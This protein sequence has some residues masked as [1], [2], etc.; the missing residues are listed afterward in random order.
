MHL[1]QV[2][3]LNG[4]RGKI[5]VPSAEMQM[6]EFSPVSH[7][8]YVFHLFITSSSFCPFFFFFLSASADLW[9]TKSDDS[10]SC[11]IHMFLFALQAIRSGAN[12]ATCI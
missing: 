6:K 10:A 7:S 12:I 4:G 3:R 5:G 2:I 8:Q 9:K 11:S 1:S